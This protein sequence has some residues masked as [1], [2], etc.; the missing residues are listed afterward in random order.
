MNKNQSLDQLKKEDGGEEDSKDNWPGMKS[1]NLDLCV[2]KCSGSYKRGIDIIYGMHR[3][4]I[5]PK[6]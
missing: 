3:K 1:D 5:H 4:G 6:D 2:S